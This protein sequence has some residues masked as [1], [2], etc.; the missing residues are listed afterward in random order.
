MPNGVKK[1][2]PAYASKHDVDKDGWACEPI[3]K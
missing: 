2:H 3:G 1:G